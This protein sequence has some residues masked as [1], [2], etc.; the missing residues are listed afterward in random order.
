MGTLLATTWSSAPGART[1]PGAGTGGARRPVLAAVDVSDG[2]DMEL[3]RRVVRA[4]RRAEGPLH[5]VHACHIVGESTLA[6]GIRG[7]GRASMRLL[8]KRVREDRLRR[9][10]DLVDDPSATLHVL[11]GRVHRVVDHVARKVGAGLVVLGSPSP[12]MIPGLLPG[13]TVALLSGGLFP[14][15]LVPRHPLAAP[16]SGRPS[17]RSAGSGGS[18]VLRT[19][20]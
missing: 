6:C 2:A 20:P 13:G 10:A 3:A 5:V 15:L 4:A 9:L 11:H 16:E 8:R 12:S 7:V 19:I 1:R 14:L 17:T 18:P